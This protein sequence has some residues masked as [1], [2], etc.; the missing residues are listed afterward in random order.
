[1]LPSSAA[2]ERNVNALVKV[3][4]FAEPVPVRR[5][6]LA[7]RKSYAREQAVLCI[8]EAIRLIESENLTMLP[9]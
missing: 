8:A 1:V 2:T 3:I 9:T 7:W 6:A 5:V 4:P